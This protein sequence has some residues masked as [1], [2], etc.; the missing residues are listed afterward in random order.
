MVSASSTFAYPRLSAVMDPNTFDV[1]M[2]IDGRPTTF[3]AKGQAVLVKTRRSSLTLA[4]REP[5]LDARLE[6]DEDRGHLV[7]GQAVDA[8]ALAVAAA[9]LVAHLLADEADEAARLL[10]A[11]GVLQHAG[12]L[13]DEGPEEDVALQTRLQGGHLGRG[14]GGRPAAARA[15]RAGLR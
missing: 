5:A 15:G 14:G 10:H 4:Q 13:A 8:Q 7:A 9:D 11:D 1:I 12:Q 6:V 3:S 2:H